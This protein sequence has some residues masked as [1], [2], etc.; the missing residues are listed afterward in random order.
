MGPNRALYERFLDLPRSE[1]DKMK[2]ELE[3]LK[4]WWHFKQHLVVDGSDLGE[5]K[6]RAVAVLNRYL[7]V[8]LEELVTK[9]L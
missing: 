1:R 9:S 8:S 7:G 6:A 2:A 3:R 4:L 5:A